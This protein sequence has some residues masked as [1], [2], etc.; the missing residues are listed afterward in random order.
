MILDSNRYAYHSRK[1]GRKRR[2]LLFFLFLFAA[3]FAAVLFTVILPALRSDRRAASSQEMDIYALWESGLYSEVAAACRDLMQIDPMNPEWLMYY[4]M[5]Q[6]YR[7]YYENALE[8]KLPL[9]DE[10]VSSLR[11][12]LLTDPEPYR[13]EISY[14]LGQAYYHKG[15]FFYD[16]TVEYIEKSLVEGY[17]GP[18]AHEY[19]AMAY[20]GLGNREKELEHLLKAYDADPSDFILLSIGKAYLALGE[21]ELAKEYLLRCLNKTEV[22]NVE[23]EC[24]FNLADIY[25]QNSEY[26]KAESQLAAIVSLDPLSAEAHFQ[27]G[28]LYYQMNNIVK[29]VAQWK[30]TEAIDPTHHGA[31]RRLYR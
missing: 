15:P 14:V 6:Y 20:G 22:P 23:K 9:L 18:N 5:A 26:L 27:L 4:G 30:K 2:Y 21:H 12:A 13:G 31:K 25:I 16:L 1:K 28:E 7:A 3:A 29:A 10:T 17:S 24:R 8:R 11:K 19:F